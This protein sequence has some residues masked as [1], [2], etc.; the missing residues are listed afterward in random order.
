MNLIFDLDGTL[1]DSRFRLYYLFQNLVPVSNLSFESYWSLKRQKVSNE[2]I[3]S[4]KFGYGAAAVEDF[5]RRWMASIES[6]EL[7]ML[8]ENFAGAHKCLERLGQQASLHV[9]TGRQYRERA[10][11]QLD[12]LGLLPY[13]DSVMVTAQKHAKE[14]LIAFI[15][16]LGPHD[17]IIG[18][19][20][21]DIQVGK[22]LG[23]NTCAVLTGFLSEKSLQ[24]YCPDMILNSVLDFR[25]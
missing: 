13:F 17:W 10:I 6:H 8:D 23:I 14:E 9:C 11:D 22:A 12:A 2:T 7:L 25:L 15:S 20:G 16:G 5:V 24:P 19:T 3:L 21:K 1:I 18:D 4:R